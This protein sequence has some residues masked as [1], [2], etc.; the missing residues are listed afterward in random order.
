[1]GQKFDLEVVRRAPVTAANGTV[2]IDP[3]Y[4]Q[5]SRQRHQAAATK[6]RTI[7]IISDKVVARQRGVATIGVK[8]K[9]G[10]A[11]CQGRAGKRGS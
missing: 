7:Q 5:L 11:R 3:E 4:R 10:G 1:M 2:E 6:T 8:R 9:V